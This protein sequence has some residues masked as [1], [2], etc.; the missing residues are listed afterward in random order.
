VGQA[1]ES[2]VHAR[3]PLRADPDAGARPIARPAGD[4]SLVVHHDLAA[5]E[6]AWRAFEETAACTPFQTYDWLSAWQR[7]IGALNGVTPAIVMVRRGDDVLMLLPLAVQGGTFARRLTFLGQELC[8]YNA[9]L[10][11]P[12]F[13]GAIEPRRFADLW[14]EIRALLQE[15]LRRATIRSP[16]KKCPRRSARSQTRCSASMPGSIRAGRT[17]PC[18]ARIGSSSIPPSAPLRRAGATAPR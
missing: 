17:R 6:Q 9:P 16:S 12:D 11:A 7:H 14:R 5:I 8:D 2:I 10:L 15:H 4:I 1:A 3:A 18:W 13:A